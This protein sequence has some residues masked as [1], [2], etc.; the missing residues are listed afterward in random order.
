MHWKFSLTSF[1]SFIKNSLRQKAEVQ[2]S[3][4]LDFCKV[5][6]VCLEL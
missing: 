4:S 3:I 1:C 6:F 5:E 2:R